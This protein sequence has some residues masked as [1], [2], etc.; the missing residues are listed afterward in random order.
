MS[1]VK[2]LG[3]T[4]AV[5]LAVLAAT[6]VAGKAAD[7]KPVAV[8]VFPGG[9]NWPIWVAQEKGLSAAGGVSVTLAPTLGSAMQLVGL[10]DAKWDIAMTALD[11]VVAYTVGQGEVPVG[12]HPE[13]FAFMG[14]DNG[15]LSVVTLPDVRRIAD[16][17]DRTVTVDALTTGYAF[18]LFDLLKHGGLERKDYRIAIV[19]GVLQRW[20]DLREK[21]HDGTLLLTP[22]EIIAK[23]QGFNQLTRAVDVYHRYQGLVGAARRDWA[24]NN[25]D[26]LVAYIRGF[27][28]AVDWLYDAKNRDE[29]IAILRKNLPQMSPEVAAQSYAVLFD[30]KLGFTR[31]ARFDVEGARKVLALRSEYGEPHITLTDPMR[32]YDASYYKAAM[33]K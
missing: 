23:A 18:V 11:N 25:K 31:K 2:K 5:A 33:T 21:K 1:V 22:F 10:I 16:L 19:G 6:P 4:V 30:S 7:L 20:E 27:S 32:F 14:V 15:F 13:L 17:K 8:I 12:R 3:R 29:A 26:T 24:K 9:F 28:E